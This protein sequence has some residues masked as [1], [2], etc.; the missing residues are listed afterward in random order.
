M[1]VSIIS[2][3]PSAFSSSPL[4]PSTSPHPPSLFPVSAAPL[5]PAVDAPVSNTSSI[6]S[7][8]P[9]L[10]SAFES[11]VQLEVCKLEQTGRNRR[12][13]QRIVMARLLSPHTRQHLMQH[14]THNST[15]P[16]TTKTSTLSSTQLP[17]SC[18]LSSAHSSSSLLPWS[19]PPWAGS[20]LSSSS[21]DRVRTLLLHAEIQLILQRG[22]SASA[23]ATACANPSASASTSTS[24]SASATTSVSAPVSSPACNDASNPSLSVLDV[25]LSELINRAVHGYQAPPGPPISPSPPSL[26]Q[27]SESQSDDPLSPQIPS[28]Q[29]LQEQIQLQQQ[30]QEEQQQQDLHHNDQPPPLGQA[31]DGNLFTIEPA[32]VLDLAGSAG[33]GGGDENDVDE[34]GDDG[35]VSH[36]HR[37]AYTRKW[38]STDIPAVR[39]AANAARM[40]MSS[41]SSSGS[42]SLSVRSSHFRKLASSRSSH[43]VSASHSHSHSALLSSVSKTA[44]S[45]RLPLSSEEEEDYLHDVSLKAALHSSSSAS[46]PSG[47]LP[48]SLTHRRPGKRSRLSV[49]PSTTRSATRPR[50]RTRPPHSPNTPLLPLSQPGLTADEDADRIKRPKVTSE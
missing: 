17:Y 21:L 16:I 1:S 18:P 33:E 5:L 34:D 35:P 8:S 36:S 24:G 45:R 47:I 38:T 28:T 29:Q 15:T 9:S 25:A 3:P 49:S 32:A 13:A 19:L 42:S 48:F 31:L 39:G 2:H 22:A 6:P 27:H 20:S 46:S 23:S 41:T 50:N 26:E 10:L 44:H 43:S 7:F 4:L 11:V 12:S 37:L 30:Q 40:A 14:N